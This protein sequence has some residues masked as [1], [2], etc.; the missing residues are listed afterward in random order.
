MNLA[1]KPNEEAGTISGLKIAILWKNDYPWDVRIE[2]IA[3]ALRDAGHQ[4]HILCANRKRLA[5]E[6]TIAGVRIVRLPAVR[7]RLLNSIVSLPFHFNPFWLWSASR[8]L[9]RERVDLLILRDV[10]LASVALTLK[11]WFGI[12]LV[13]DMAENY[14]AMYR[15]RADKGGWNALVSWVVKNPPLIS[16]I[17]RMAVRASAHVFVVVE[18][19]ALRLVAEG[20]DATKISIVSNTPDIDQ[21]DSYSARERGRPLQLVY[22]GLIQERGMDLV[23]KAL[24]QLRQEDIHARFLVIGDGAYLPRLKALTTELGMDDAVTFTGWVDNRA[25]PRHVADSDIGVIPHKRNPHSDTTIPNKLFDY[26]A[27]GRAVIVSDAAPLK[28]IVEEENCGLVF[29]AGS[30]ESLAATVRRMAAD[31]AMVEE[32]GRRGLAAVQRRYHWRY[33]AGRVVW[34]VG[35]V[36][37]R[38]GVDKEIQD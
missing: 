27:C 38:A 36:S 14:P 15:D 3:H 16:L 33:D 11:R 22:A 5:R 23:V 10:P 25:I 20:A 8:V 12:P 26:M 9:R 18:E 35:H 1:R 19:S 21:F 30:V 4:V 7:S 28:R 6:E 29:T 31:R 37:K 32:M 24:R 2:K 34:I 13:L 17:E